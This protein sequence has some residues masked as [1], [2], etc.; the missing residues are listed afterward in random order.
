MPSASSLAKSSL[1]SRSSRL[2]GSLRASGLV[3]V[4]FGFFSGVAAVAEAGAGAGDGLVGAAS[5]LEEVG[6]WDK[7]SMSMM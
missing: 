6:N 5:G 1:M 4:S 3:L 2:D 7:T